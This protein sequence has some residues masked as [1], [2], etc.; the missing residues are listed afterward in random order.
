MTIDRKEQE[1][2]M[3]SYLAQQ[4]L[5]F[6]LTGS[7]LY[8]LNGKNVLL[9][10]GASAIGQEMLRHLVNSKVRQIIVVDISESGLHQI[11]EWAEE[12]RL[13]DSRIICELGD[14]R[15][16]KF[17]K[18]IFQKFRPNIVWNLAS[19]KSLLLG[20]RC[21]VTFCRFNLGS[22][23]TL[24]KVASKIPSV[25]RFVYISSDKACQP[26]QCYGYTKWINEIL[27][28]YFAERNKKVKFGNLRPCNILDTA[29]SFF[30]KKCLLSIKQSKP[31]NIRIIDGKVPKR[32][33]IPLSVAAK[34]VIKVAF[35]CECGEVFS[36]NP[37]C[38]APIAVDQLTRLI[39][40][41]SGISDVDKW[42]EENILFVRG[43]DG[44]KIVEDLPR[45]EVVDGTPLVKLE[46]EHV[47]PTWVKNQIKMV[48]RLAN[49]IDAGPKIMQI[50]Q[51]IV[52]S[53]IPKRSIVPAPLRCV[54]ALT[55]LTRRLALVAS[56]A[57][58]RVSRQA[59]LFICRL[60]I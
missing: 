42:F 3:Q 18:S 8:Y 47:R 37:E 45:G 9:A 38:I 22:N 35:C 52:K 53:N 12:V 23:Y 40:K 4:R 44:E 1:K 56:G 39:A 34:L 48:L 59:R 60:I 5:R 16:K 2:I 28:R 20:N 21:I 46:P 57:W 58:I 27:V 25:E 41:Q 26:S 24:L 43:E 30:V 31:I 15:D 33:F 50:L 32:H 19:L 51:R 14:L 6:E 55:F 7:D 17:L 36:M 10:G 13:A 29:G 54:S 11:L 49:S